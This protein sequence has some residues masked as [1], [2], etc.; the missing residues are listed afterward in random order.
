[1]TSHDFTKPH[2][3]GSGTLE[4]GVGGHKARTA[5]VLGDRVEYLTSL[6]YPWKLREEVQAEGISGM[7]GYSLRR[8]LESATVQGGISGG[9]LTQVIF[10]PIEVDVEPQEAGSLT[11]GID[12]GILTQVIFPPVEQ[13]ADTEEADI[14]SM[15][16]ASGS[17]V[18]VIFPPVEYT[19][20]PRETEISTFGISSGTLTSI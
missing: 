1:M 9:L 15:G 11:P 19:A 13:D 20:E 7:E 14:A 4:E 16:I 10:P 2:S 8:T 3:A 5:N 18:Q 17:L 12:S 6:P